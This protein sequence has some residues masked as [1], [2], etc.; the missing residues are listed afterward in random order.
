DGVRA[1]LIAAGAGSPAGIERAASAVLAAREVRATITDL[2]E[3]GSPVG[4]R[5]VDVRDEEA[6]R[7]AVKDIH[8]EHGRLDGIVY[9]AGV[10]EDRLVAE[11]SAE[12]FRRVFATKVDG[13]RVLLDAAGELPDGGPRFAVLF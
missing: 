5:A 3:L 7:A 2:R 6:V 8:A 12:S 13:A 4:Y 9:A 11:K 10:I 1:A